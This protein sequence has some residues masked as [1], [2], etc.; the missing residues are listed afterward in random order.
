VPGTKSYNAQNDTLDQ[1]WW[2]VDGT[3]QIIGR[4]ASDIAM[5]LMG[6]HKP[7]YTPNIDTGD[8]VV[9]TN[10][11]KIKFSPGKADKKVYT[12]YT[13]YTGQSS[14]TAANRLQRKP[15]LVMQDAVRRMLPKNKLGRHMLAKLKIYKGSEHPHAAQNPQPLTGGRTLK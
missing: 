2:I 1:K 11:D 15:E 10:C 9:L 8:F 3:D 14:E 12:W 5:V 4:I 7:T 6:K 13:G